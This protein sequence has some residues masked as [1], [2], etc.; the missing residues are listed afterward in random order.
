MHCGSVRKYIQAGV[1]VRNKIIKKVLPE[2]CAYE[3][4][5][6]EAHLASKIPTNKH[7]R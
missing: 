1:G 3:N 6:S 7:A 2:L 4:N 5:S